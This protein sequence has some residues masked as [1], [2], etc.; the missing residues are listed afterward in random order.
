MDDSVIYCTACP[1]SKQ[2]GWR[3]RKLY[4]LNDYS[5]CFLSFYKPGWWITLLIVLWL[6]CFSLLLTESDLF[7]SL[8]TNFLL[9]AESVFPFFSCQQYCWLI[10]LLT[11]TVNM[12]WYKPFFCIPCSV[13]CDKTR[14]Y[15]I[16]YVILTGWKPLHREDHDCWWVVMVPSVLKITL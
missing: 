11:C 9:N 6:F 7:Y 15:L 12:K 5:S 14:I 8:Q 4:R 13:K 1:I 3:S 16:K 2:G 10:H